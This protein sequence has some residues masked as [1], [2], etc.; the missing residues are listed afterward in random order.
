MENDIQTMR[1]ELATLQREV[2]RQRR[3]TRRA[4]VVAVVAIILA[5]IAP[6]SVLGANFLDLN[7]N[8]PHNGNIN[9]IA[10]AGITRGCNPPDYNAYCPNNL[11][12]REEM[13]S[14]LARTAGLGGNA[15]VANAAY[16][17]GFSANAL[18]RVNGAGREPVI[19]LAG[20]AKT[21]TSATITAPTAGYVYATGAVSFAAGNNGYT[22]L[23]YARVGDATANL[24]SFPLF[25]FV[26]F[27]SGANAAGAMSPTSVFR[28]G[29]GTRT[30]YLESGI[31]D[32][33]G[34]PVAGS[35]NL[36]LLFVPFGPG[37]AIAADLDE[38]NIPNGPVGPWPPR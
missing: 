19:A 6:L 11:V 3:T 4:V 12:T 38:M 26:G 30:F 7:S 18:V 25:Q 14:F 22:A 34:N 5:A 37:G 24:V 29:P 8:S 17:N 21:I 32:G 2:R 15:P 10:D 20:G 36:S 28:V 31:S 9:A 1:R 33:A 27:A 16:L 13:A 35:G 23:V